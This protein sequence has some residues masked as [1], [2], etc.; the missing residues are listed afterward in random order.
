MNDEI[1]NEENGHSKD[2]E[3]LVTSYA[4]IT[5]LKDGS[6]QEQGVGEQFSEVFWDDAKTDTFNHQHLRVPQL[7]AKLTFQYKLENGRVYARTLQY[8][9]TSRPAGTYWYR[10]NMNVQLNSAVY[11]Y[12]KSPDAMWQDTQWHSYVVNLEVAYSPSLG[13]SI[14]IQVQYDGTNNGVDQKETWGRWLTLD[15]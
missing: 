6:F 7:T 2:E 11:H 5:E 10:A 8:M 3:R 1:N 4:H 15:L 12:V 13:A 9:M 14:N